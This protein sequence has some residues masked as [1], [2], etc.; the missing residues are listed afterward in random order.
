MIEGTE[1]D[2]TWDVAF[3]IWAPHKQHCCPVLLE[4]VNCVLSS[5]TEGD[6]HVNP[7][8]NVCHPIVFVTENAGDS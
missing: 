7:L 4:E 3:I 6:Y 1:R 8:L 5:S 2:V